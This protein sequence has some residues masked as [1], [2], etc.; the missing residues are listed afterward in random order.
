MHKVER[1]YIR[2]R[3]R[4][5][6]LNGEASGLAPE[7]LHVLFAAASDEGR[8]LTHASAADRA[9]FLAYEVS[10]D[11]WRSALVA[12][13]FGRVWGKE[14]WDR[15]RAAMADNAWRP[16][17]FGDDGA[18]ADRDPRMWVL[19]VTELGGRTVETP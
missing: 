1:N 12:G 18:S 5:W 4:C 15:G 13:P 17:L 14:A 10:E 9:S 8:K 3:V 11:G 19:R 6:T 7:V 16:D 2:L